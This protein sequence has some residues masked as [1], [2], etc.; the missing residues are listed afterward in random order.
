MLDVFDVYID[1][2]K[3]VWL[4]DFGLYD[5]S[6]TVDRSESAAPSGSGLQSFI[7][8][9][10]PLLFSYAELEQIYR[11]AM[12][13]KEHSSSPAVTAFPIF[14]VVESKSGVMLSDAGTYRAPI[15]VFAS[16]GF[17]GF[18]SVI[19]GAQGQTERSDASSDDDREA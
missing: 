1:K 8:Y 11:V 19:A 15:D 16:E 3:R 7:Q 6:H 14:R 18:M 9:A 17:S 5:T 12:Y 4:V 13:S 10:D 2:K